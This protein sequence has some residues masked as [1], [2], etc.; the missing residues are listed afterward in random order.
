NRSLTVIGGAASPGQ[1]TITPGMGG[2]GGIGGPG[3]FPQIG[4]SSTGLRN[5]AAGAAVGANNFGRMSTAVRT[6]LTATTSDHV[7]TILEALES[8]TGATAVAGRMAENPIASAFGTTRVN[9]TPRQMV[10]GS[11]GTVYAL[12]VSG[13]SVLPLAPAT[14]ATQPQIA[15]TRG[16]V[17]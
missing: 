14:S 7:H 8:R 11:D 15:T 1:V 2:P 13:L 12:T 4:V 6:N 16:I 5:I 3:G 17:N 10:V 9:V